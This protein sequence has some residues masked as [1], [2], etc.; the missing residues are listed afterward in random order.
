MSGSL[1]VLNDLIL[2]RN[3]AK[4]SLSSSISYKKRGLMSATI[5]MIHSLFFYAQFS[6]IGNDQIGGLSR[7]SIDLNMDYKA[8]GSLEKLLEFIGYDF[9]SSYTPVCNEPFSNFTNSICQAVEC[10]NLTVHKHIIDISYMKSIHELWTR[11]YPLGNYAG[12]PAAIGLTLFSFIWPHLK[13]ILMHIYF[14]KKTSKKRQRNVNYW[15][16]V[17]GK[18][19]LTD[20]LVMCLIISI[21]NINIQL[22][23]LQLWEG[24]SS[25][26]NIM[27]I[28]ICDIIAMP[29]FNCN[30]TCNMIDMVLNN[31]LTPSNLPSSNINVTLQMECLLAMYVFCA[32]V[33]LSLITSI[34]IDNMNKINDRNDY[35]Y[36]PAFKIH[37]THIIL[38]VIEFGLIV[39]TLSQSLLKRYV[40]GSLPLALKTFDIYLDKEYTIIDI[41]NIAGNGGNYDKFIGGIVWIFIIIMPLLR[42]LSLFILL[43]FPIPIQLQK[44]LFH[45][46]TYCSV[47]LAIDVLALII[48]F[49]NMS[50]GPMSAL[51]LNSK[52]PFCTV[53]NKLFPSLLYYTTIVHY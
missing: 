30:N 1:L 22:S 48:P 4:K 32:A 9:C 53:L 5:L 46:S 38:L 52:F 3:V 36:V 13:L 35:L 21:F 7:A 27:C 8:T 28:D 50:F 37:F 45:I 43:L 47:F 2:E 33:I 24:I 15:L 12:R 6:G 17:F 29:H 19:S 31:T 40:N 41:L 51:L 39:I 18:W 23:I 25:V 10:H 14:Y 20:V 34:V 26:F 16:T 11:N 42:P 44:N 49:I